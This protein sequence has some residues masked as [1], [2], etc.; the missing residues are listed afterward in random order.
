M[1]EARVLAPDLDAHLPD[2]L[3]ERQRLDVA[4]RPA[5]LDH[6]DFR[7]ARAATDELLDLVRDVRNHLH[8]A[9]QIVAAAL[10][11][12]HA[13]V[14][15]ARREVVALAHLCLDEALVVAQVEVGFGAVFRDEHFAV[16]E[17]AH[18]ARIDVQ[19]RIQLH[20]RDLDAAGFENRGEGGGSDAFAKGGDYT[21][22][23]KDEFRHR[24]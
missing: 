13:F 12:D 2:R 24:I 7:V 8:G 5:D 14:D 23:D 18:G 19:I 22:S 6:R 11:A 15:L 21:T 3:E 4:D 16:L 10:L 17:R 9:A 20:H 1:D